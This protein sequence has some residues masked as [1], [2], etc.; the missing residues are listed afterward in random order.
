MQLFMQNA[1]MHHIRTIE[2]TT[3]MDQ[4]SK[5]SNTQIGETS[6]ETSTHPFYRSMSKA[7]LYQNTQSSAG[8]STNI[9]IHHAAKPRGPKIT[10]ASGNNTRIENG[11]HQANSQRQRSIPQQRR[12]QA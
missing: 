11:G 8:G 9:F 10:Y 3:G 4:E 5:T 7:I 6:L 2:G 12:T 1:A